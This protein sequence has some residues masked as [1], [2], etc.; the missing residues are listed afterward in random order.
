MTRVMAIFGHTCYTEY[1]PTEYRLLLTSAE[2][3]LALR[4]QTDRSFRL[5]ARQAAAI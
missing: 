5:V 2:L 3:L 4:G 1:M